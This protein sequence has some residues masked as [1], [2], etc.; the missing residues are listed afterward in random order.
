MQGDFDLELRIG[1]IPLTPAKPKPR[2]KRRYAAR[3]K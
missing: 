1:A 2:W 3:G